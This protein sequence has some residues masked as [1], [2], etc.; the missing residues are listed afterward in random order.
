MK[1]SPLF[2]DE[3]ILQRGQSNLLWGYTR[4]NHLVEGSFGEYL[5]STNAKINGYFEV[6]LPSLPAG[7]PYDLKIVADEEKIIK[8]VMVGDVFLLGGQSNMEMPISETLELYGE[9][10]EDTCEP[11]IRMFEVPKEYDFQEERKEISNGHWIK[12]CGEELLEF[13]AAGFFTAQAIKRKHNIPIGLIQTAVG[14]TPA[15]AWCSE[16]TIKRMGLYSDELEKCK[17][18]AYP[19]KVEEIESEREQDWLKRA[20]EAF[21][22]EAKQKGN[23]TVPSIW[24][25]NELEDFCGAIR[26]KKEFNLSAKEY[27]KEIELLLGA[28]IDADTVYING[29]YIGE[30]GYRYPPRYYT[31]PGGVLKEGK[32]ILEIHM[33]VFRSKGGFMPGKQYGLRFIKEKQLFLDLAGEWTYEIMESMETLPDSTFFTY[34]AAGLYN[35]MLSPLSRWNIAGILYYQG[36]SNTGNPESYNEEMK[37][38]INDWRKLWKNEELPFIYVQLAGYSEGNLVNQG[39]GW[40]RLRQEQEKTLEVSN[41]AM[42]VAY[43]IGEYNDLHPLNKKTLGQRLALAVRSLIYGEDIVATG[44]KL[45]KINIDKGEKLRVK[46]S[47]SAGQLCAVNSNLEKEIFDV[48]LL[49]KDGRYKKSRAFIEKDELIVYLDLIKEPVGI[50]YAWKDSPIDANLYN[51]EGLP[52]LPFLREWN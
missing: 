43:D 18:P 48:E 8:D 49:D 29:C 13:S 34:K 51:V 3:M 24:S 16:K 7:G 2:S 14:G 28:I 17:N 22:K 33:S 39:T 44:P 31:I 40:A 11:N 6:N 32:N 36:E 21:V 25:D 35:G 27:K 41:T 10:I 37:A 52:A 23:L 5:F 9:E 12:A 26:L 42:V 50:R 15:K 19:K 1:L 20:R 30:T 45:E 4:A 47:S 46:F 38:L